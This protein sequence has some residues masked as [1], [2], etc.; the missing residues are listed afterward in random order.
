MSSVTVP[1]NSITSMVWFHAPPDFRSW[2]VRMK[3]YA[4]SLF[5]LFC[6]KNIDNAGILYDHVNEFIQLCDT[7][8]NCH[9]DRRCMCVTIAGQWKDAKMSCIEYEE[10]RLRFRLVLPILVRI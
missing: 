4:C 5:P 9:C 7:G 8:I 2:S 10:W 3:Y 1:V 6:R